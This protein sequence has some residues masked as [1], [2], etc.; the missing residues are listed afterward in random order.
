LLSARVLLDDLGSF[1]ASGRPSLKSSH[2]K[3]ESRGSDDVR[4]PGGRSKKGRSPKRKPN[5]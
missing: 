4:D 1:G 5:P 2:R 3:P